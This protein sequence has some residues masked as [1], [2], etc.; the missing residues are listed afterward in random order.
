MM[1]KPAAKLPFSFNSHYGACRHLQWNG[2][3]RGITREGVIPDLIEHP[4]E[5]IPPLWR[6][7]E[8]WKIKK[9]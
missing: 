5:A 4:E 1:M 7:R 3:H 6:Y 8:I 2:N 9:I